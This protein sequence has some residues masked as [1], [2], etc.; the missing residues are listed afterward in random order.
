MGR[1]A[2]DGQVRSGLQLADDFR[3]IFGGNA[4]TAHAG[5]D[6]QVDRVF[7]AEVC[8]GSLE[9]PD[10]CVIDLDPKDAPFSDVIRTAIAVHELCDA[11]GL[12]NHV[13]TTGKTGLHILVPLLAPG[14][15]AAGLL[16]LVRTIAMFEL[17]FLTAGPDSQTLVVALYYSVFAAGVR[18]GQSVDAMAV[19]Y[20]VTTLVWLIIALRFVNPTQLVT[21]VKE[22]PR[23]A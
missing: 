13:K 2:F 7:R 20:M 23:M 17:T 5:V 4:E 16:V 15:L 8:C 12:P 10:W 11:I 21:R 1:E 14:I 19:T 9:Q 18:A 6:F 22:Q 3:Q